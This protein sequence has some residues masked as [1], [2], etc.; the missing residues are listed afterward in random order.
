M[1]LI[2]DAD[3]CSGHGRCYSVAPDLLEADDEGFVTA[4][5]SAL[6]VRPTLIPDARRAAESCPEEAISI[7]EDRERTDESER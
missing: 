5:G 4:R 3:K 2:V 1:R 7:I 6:D